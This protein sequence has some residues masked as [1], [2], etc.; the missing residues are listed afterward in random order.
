MDLTAVQD[1]MDDFDF[2]DTEPAN[3]LGLQFDDYEEP[4]DFVI[5]SYQRTD[6]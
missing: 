2:V 4:E 1:A 5:V 6:L 3:R